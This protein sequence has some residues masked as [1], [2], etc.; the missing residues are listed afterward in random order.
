LKYRHLIVANLFR[1][2]IRTALTLGSFAVALFLFGLLAIVR[3]AF[4]QGLE[5]AGTDRLVVVNKV[6]I[7]QP[8]PISYQERLER[9]P[10]VKEVT[11]QNWFGGIYQDPKNFF[12]QMAID[13]DTFHSMYPEFIIPEEQWQD[14]KKDREGAIVGVK[15]AK[16][17]GWKLGDRI[18]I[19]GTIFPGT[20]EF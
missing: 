4:S 6:S 18:P 16:R 1:K 11:H 19:K 17:Y 9:M 8:L 20:W 12:A 13:D 15:L 10:G 7:I 14:Y 3:G 5:A 2:K